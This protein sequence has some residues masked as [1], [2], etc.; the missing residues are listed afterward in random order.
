[1]PTLGTG[2]LAA[3]VLGGIACGIN[4][5]GGGHHY[6]HQ[7]ATKQMTHKL[8][9]NYIKEVLALSSRAHNRLPKLKI[10][11]REFDFEGQW[12]FIMELPQ[13]WGNRLLE[14]TNKILCAPGPKRKEQEP[15]RDKT[16][17]ACEFPG[18]SGRG[19]G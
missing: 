7:T 14:G 1:M 10:W 16:R 2:A 12:V 3:T 15:T 11:Q 13:D 4:P 8:E 6:P 17:L 9:N 5:P 19:L 18:V